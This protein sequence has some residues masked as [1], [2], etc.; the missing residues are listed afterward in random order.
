M[1]NT[2]IKSYV[3]SEACGI[4][5]GGLIKSDTRWLATFSHKEERMKSVYL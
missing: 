3:V 1:I 5:S 2:M 4:L